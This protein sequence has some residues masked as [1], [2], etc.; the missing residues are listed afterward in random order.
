MIAHEEYS[1][2]G[3]V[4][5]ELGCHKPQDAAEPRVAHCIHSL[6]SSKKGPVS[7][8]KIK[9]SMHDLGSQQAL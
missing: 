6:V 9:P 1:L 4:E 3:D 5:R 2:E 8:I 7:C